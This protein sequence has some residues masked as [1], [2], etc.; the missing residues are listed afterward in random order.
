MMFCSLL[1]ST[2][3][4]NLAFLNEIASAVSF[5]LMFFLTC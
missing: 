5:I 2:A 4:Q 1:G 3:F